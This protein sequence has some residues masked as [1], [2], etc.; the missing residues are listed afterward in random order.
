[1]WARLSFSRPSRSY[2]WP[3]LRRRR[4]N[5]GLKSAPLNGDVERVFAFARPV[6]LTGQHETHLG[7]IHSV[8]VLL[9]PLSDDGNHVNRI[10]FTRIACFTSNARVSRDWLAGA[11]FKLM[12]AV[13]I[14][15]IAQDSSCRCVY[16]LVRLP[17]C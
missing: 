4:D 2:R 16:G 8:S 9:L 14:E 10:I 5:I 13:N 11:S 17:A 12:E 1:L 6:F 15:D 7:S 3:F